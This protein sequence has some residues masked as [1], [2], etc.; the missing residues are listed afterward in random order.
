MVPPVQVAVPA[1]SME[2]LRNSLLPVPLMVRM[3]GAETMVVPVPSMVPLV[4]VSSLETRRSPPPPSLPPESSN[5]SAVTA[6]TPT[7]V[8]LRVTTPATA[9]T[10]A[11]A[12]VAPGSRVCVSVKPL[13]SIRASRAAVKAPLLVPPRVSF[14][15]EVWTVTVPVLL[16]ATSMVVA[17][18][19]VLVT[20]PALLN[21]VTVPPRVKPKARAAWASKVALARLLKAA[22]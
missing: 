4:Q 12:R 11:P 20:V 9:M 2:R 3:A 18:P 16:K 1:L 17:A 21:W 15:V 14:R 6:S 10:P 7:A 22:P 13:N 19:A 8:L 5:R